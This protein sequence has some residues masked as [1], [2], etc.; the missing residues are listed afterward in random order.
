[1]P[2]VQVTG[3]HKTYGS[4]RAVD[5][6]AF[7]VESGEIFGLVGPNGAGETTTLERIEGLRKPDSGAITVFGLDQQAGGYALRERIGV[8]LRQAALP[9]RIRV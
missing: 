9:D 5:G 2:A 1:M 3:L 7:A 4:V 8:Q 6:V